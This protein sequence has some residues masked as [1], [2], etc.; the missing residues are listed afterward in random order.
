MACRALRAVRNG[1]VAHLVREGADGTGLWS[2]ELH[3]GC[4]SAVVALRALVAV[5]GSSQ[6]EPLAGVSASRA[7]Q[8]G[9]CCCLTVLAH[10]AGV[11]DVSRALGTEAPCCTRRA[12]ANSS[13]SYL[14]PVAAGGAHS[15]H[16]NADIAE[17][18]G[19]ALTDM[20]QLQGVEG[21]V[22]ACYAVCAACG[23]RVSTGGAAVLALRTGTGLAAC[24]AEPANRA[25][26]TC[27]CV[28]SRIWRADLARQT[29]ERCR[30]LC[31]R[32][33]LSVGAGHRPLLRLG[34]CVADGA[35]GAGFISLLRVKSSCTSSL[36]GAQ[37]GV[38]ALISCLA[39]LAVHVA[40]SRHEARPTLCRVAG[41]GGMVA[42]TSEARGALH[43]R[44]G[45]IIRAL[46]IG[47]RLRRCSLGGAEVPCRAHLAVCGPGQGVS[48]SGASRADCLV[49]EWAE[50]PSDTLRAGSGFC[51]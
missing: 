24:R 47:A 4:T 28:V 35:L 29:I 6:A 7:I 16:S 40:R 38:G 15:G 34:A 46:T 42:L 30:H 14:A 26:Y 3:L 48:T 39:R 45:A 50:V 41:K 49:R 17:V 9:R 12:I 20:V 1:I 37:G 36:G 11:A 21:T 13:T 10:W 23:F 25:V 5:S 19:G 22:P 2:H 18:T 44:G 8:Q 43:A 31:G 27:R 33:H 32:A 51:K